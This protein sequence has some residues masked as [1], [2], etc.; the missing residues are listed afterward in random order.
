MFSLIN[1]VRSGQNVVHRVN[2]STSVKRVLATPF[3]PRKSDKSSKDASFPRLEHLRERLAADDAQLE[4]FAPNMDE[5]YDSSIFSEKA[6]NYLTTVNK[7]YNKRYSRGGSNGEGYVGVEEVLEKA[8][9]YNEAAKNSL[10]K[11]APEI[12]HQMRVKVSAAYVQ[13]A[14]EALPANAK[15]P[16]PILKVIIPDELEVLYRDIGETDPSNQNKYSPIP[17]L[18]HKYNMLL[19]MTSIN[20]SSHCRYCY[21]SDLFNGSSGKSKADL[22]DVAEYI[23]AYNEK[24]DASI[25]DPS[26]KYDPLV[27]CMVTTEGEPLL[28]LKEILLSGGDPLTLPN[29][30]IARYLTLMAEAGM[31]TI[32]IGSKEVAFNPNRFDA[33]FWSA[34]D[35]FHVNYPQVRIELVG[36]Y[37]HPYELVQPLTD[38]EGNYVY[39]TATDY[40]VHPDVELTLN[41]INSRRSWFGHFNQ[42][43]IIAG[44][45]DTPEIM[46]LLLH[47]TNKLGIGMHNVY[48][49][50][51]VIGNPHFRGDLTI[52]KQYDLLEAAKIGLSGLENHAR[53]IMSTEQGKMEVLGH[54]DGK[55][56]LRINR[57]IHGRKPENTTIIVDASKL[58]DEKFYWLTQNVID[59][60]IDESSKDMLNSGLDGDTQFIKD[61]KVAASL[62]A[63]SETINGNNND[64]F[65]TNEVVA[66]TKQQISITVVNNEGETVDAIETCIGDHNTAINGRTD[67]A[68]A[69]ILVS[70]GHVEMVCGGQLSCTTCVGKVDADYELI[71]ATLDELDATDTLDLSMEDERG[72]LRACCQLKVRPGQKY[73]FQLI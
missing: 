45:N 62:A 40:V 31:R 52:A 2:L 26:S 18:L 7:L 17:G 68:L 50:R 69:D 29:V 22:V 36:H 65:A 11:L 10:L 38:S 39:S 73:Q 57:F 48:A 58:Q 13:H 54:K 63:T 41:H 28:P 25:E 5:R 14:L 47:L 1:L 24:I 12:Q 61:V 53:L 51:E 66:D 59:N 6:Q 56:Y 27:G 32:R 34:L 43:P 42:F 9:Y 21:R 72:E 3:E 70:A 46:R 16:S 37:V 19:A 20:C 67:V 49:C 23:K 33:A 44:V 30:T 15:D 35:L 60:A 4:R 55:V 8:P 64:V 71:P